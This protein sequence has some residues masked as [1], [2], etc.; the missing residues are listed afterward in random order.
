M[1]SAD[2]LAVLRPG[3]IGDVVVRNRFIRSATSE[4]MADARGR[5]DEPL[6]RALYVELARGGVGLIFTGH[7]AVHQRGKYTFGMT[8]LASDVNLESFGRTVDAVHREGA[9]IF[10]QL[11]HAGS[12][13]RAGDVEPLAPSPVPNPQHGRMPT[14]ASEAEIAEA[15]QAFADAARRVKAAGFDGVHLHAGHGYLLSEFLSPLT[16]RRE[17]A[18]GGS[19]EARQLLLREVVTAVRGAV[20]PDFPVTVKLGIR[21]FPP[22]G[23]T[24]DEGLETAEVVA[25]LG[26]AAVEV[27]AGLTSPKMES[28]AA[29]AGLTRR[30]ALEDMVVHRVFGPWVPEAYFADAARRL[31]GRVE[32]PLIL[33][34]GLRTVETMEAIVREGVADFVSLARPLIREPGLVRQ[35][36]AGRRGTVD[37]VSCNICVMHEGVHPL[38]CWRKS[39]KD[40]ALH[41]AHRLT[42]RLR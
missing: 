22:G 13:A 7:C 8:T 2:G 3:R 19:L 23:L 40:L 33:V 20:G 1:S 41:A 32:C 4:T 18:W 24:I 37:C 35:I 28:A 26:V 6:Y 9:R 5:L 29:Y 30:R 38:R 15:I 14:A 16:N 11:N 21:D 34:G 10:A 39:K 42:G 12:Q 17:D 36:E 27:T 31:R 25:G